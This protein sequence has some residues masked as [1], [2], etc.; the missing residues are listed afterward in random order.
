MRI[1]AGNCIPTFTRTVLGWVAPG[2]MYP[3][4]TVTMTVFA[5]LFIP[6]LATAIFRYVVPVLFV[7]DNAA[8]SWGCTTFFFPLPTTLTIIGNVSPLTVNPD[9]LETVVTSLLVPATTITVIVDVIPVNFVFYR[10]T[11]VRIKT[12]FVLPLVTF[13]AI[14]R[15]V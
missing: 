7:T 13:S 9:F 11:T 3:N 12:C 14:L 10:S 2:C 15:N 6:A 8:T 4:F 1:L 5:F